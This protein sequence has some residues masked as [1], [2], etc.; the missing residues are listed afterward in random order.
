MIQAK[1]KQCE[2]TYQIPAASVTEIWARTTLVT[3]CSVH[4]SYCSNTAPLMG[5]Q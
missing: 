3:M 1:I 5:A 4:L 2:D